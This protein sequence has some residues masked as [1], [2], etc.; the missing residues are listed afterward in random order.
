MEKLGL[1]KEQQEKVHSLQLAAE[2]EKQKEYY[3]YF[4]LA[5]EAHI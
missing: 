5:T 2:A 4:K 3:E 1:E